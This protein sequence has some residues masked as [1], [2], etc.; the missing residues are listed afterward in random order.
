[1]KLDWYNIKEIDKID[2]PALII[3]EDRVKANIQTAIG[4]VHHLDRLRPHVKTNKSGEATRLML[5][6]GITKFK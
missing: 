2:S 1:M 3:F 4:M 5:D 6:A